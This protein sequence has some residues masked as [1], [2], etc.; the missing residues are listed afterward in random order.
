MRKNINNNQV[1]LFEI[2]KTEISDAT[3]LAKSNLGLYAQRIL[4]VCASQIR[5]DDP[6]DKIYSFNIPDFAEFF[7]LSTDKIHAKLRNALYELRSSTIILPIDRG[8]VTG[9]INWGHI[10][11]GKVDISFDPVL[12]PLYQ[13][14]LSGK[15]PLR[16]IRG[17]AYSYTYRFYEL[18]LLKLQQEGKD[19]KVKF[20]I[21]IDELRELLRIE[22]AYKNYADIRKRIIIPIVADINGRKFNVTSKII[23]NDY[24]NLLVSYSEVK[25]G[26]NTG[27]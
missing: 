24:C 17:F 4:R 3:V 25:K 9:Y 7:G 23:E 6:D 13:K 10:F 5:D 18:F 16:Y 11:D 21:T 20:Y 15:Y 27:F 12:K 19:N 8:R 22:K 26:R 1:V 2:P 14:N